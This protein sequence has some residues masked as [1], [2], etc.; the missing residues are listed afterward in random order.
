MRTPQGAAS[1]HGHLL[2]DGR[3][4]RWGVSRAMGWQHGTGPQV[5]AGRRHSRAAA[6]RLVMP[7]H[8]LPGRGMAQ[9]GGAVLA[10]ARPRQRSS[11]S[12]CPPSRPQPRTRWLR[13]SWR[14]LGATPPSF[15]ARAAAAAMVVGLA[16]DFHKVRVERPGILPGAPGP[17]PPRSP[18]PRPR[19][20]PVVERQAE[21]WPHIRRISRAHSHAS[22]PASRAFAAHRRCWIDTSAAPAVRRRNGRGA[23]RCPRPVSAPVQRAR[24]RPYGGGACR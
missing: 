14:S 5:E 1:G 21:Q 11:T 2:I 8:P 7:L 4:V 15:G 23:V 9:D 18:L 10:Q 13:C 12:S 6:D 16:H 17:G 24:P 22:A 3:E 19:R 20:T